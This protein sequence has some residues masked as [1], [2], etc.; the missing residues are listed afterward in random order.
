MGA[1]SR[2]DY[3]KIKLEHIISIDRWQHWT[4]VSDMI[5]RLLSMGV[6]GGGESVEMSKEGGRGWRARWLGGAGVVGATGLGAAGVS[7]RKEVAA[8]PALEARAGEHRSVDAGRARSPARWMG[9]AGR[10][11]VGWAVLRPSDVVRREFWL[12]ETALRADPGVMR[13]EALQHLG[14]AASDVAWNARAGVPQGGRVRVELRSVAVR[15]AERACVRLEAAGVGPERLLDP[16]DVLEAAW[17]ASRESAMVEAG[18]ILFLGEQESV[19]IWL[20]DAAR[21]VRNL[22]L[23]VRSVVEEVAGRLAGA[24]PHGEPAA[25]PP[26]PLEETRDEEVA[27]TLAARAHLEVSRI[28]TTAGAQ[29]TDRPARPGGVWVC[30]E[31][32]IAPALVTALALRLGLPVH[33]WEASGGDAEW[34]TE[35]PLARRQEWNVYVGGVLRLWQRRREDEATD[36]CFLPPVRSGR[37]ARRFAHATLMGA[38]ALVTLGAIPPAWH[39]HRLAKDMADRVRRL[40]EE[41]QRLQRIDTENRAALHRLSAE[42]SRVEALQEL[43]SARLRWPRFLGGL[44]QCLEEVEDA[45]LDGLHPAGDA[46]T[47]SSGALH[48]RVTGCLLASETGLQSGALNEL[49]A[50]PRVQALLAQVARL[51]SI[52]RIERERFARTEPGMLR[53]DLELALAE[54][55]LR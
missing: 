7:E 48:V 49:E 43:A 31:S 3:A 4:I 44:E 47:R 18:L 28:F 32:A 11:G 30:A 19:L 9:W 21:R 23:G 37:L 33:A 34:L 22:A 17:R 26:A 41:V 54:E 16:A 38:A 39:Y 24:D 29:T 12:E 8:A 42:R 15:Q 40:D 53:F 5:L 46:A 55:A 27:A 6:T 45:W 10:S 52:E 14:S 50:E 35:P 51:P 13:F 1:R 25:S 2:P 36:A 20:D